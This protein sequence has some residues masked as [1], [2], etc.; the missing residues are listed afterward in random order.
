MVGDGEPGDIEAGVGEDGRTNT[1]GGV[2]IVIRISWI[3]NAITRRFYGEGEE[4]AE[5]RWGGS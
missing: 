5:I 2:V 3:K 4:G 1:R